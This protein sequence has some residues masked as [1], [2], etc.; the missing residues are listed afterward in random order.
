LNYNSRQDRALRRKIRRSYSPRRSRRNLRKKI[1]VEQKVKRIANGLGY[2][3]IVEAPEISS[4]TSTT[5]T[6]KFSEEAATDRGL[7]DKYYRPA[8]YPTRDTLTEL[9]SSEA[10]SK[11]PP[12]LLGLVIL[13]LIFFR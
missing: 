9:G 10:P 4:T 3:G 5:Y 6:P 12:L 8:H 2:Y 11:L 13:Y 7:I 1:E